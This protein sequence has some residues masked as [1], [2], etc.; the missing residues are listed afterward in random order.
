M[1]VNDTSA[2]NPTPNAPIPVS[3]W[4]DMQAEASNDTAVPLWARELAQAYV[5]NDVY[6][7]AHPDSAYAKMGLV[8]DIAKESAWPD[9]AW[10]VRL[11]AVLEQA[12][13]KNAKQLVLLLPYRSAPV[14]W[15]QWS[16]I[17]LERHGGY[18]DNLTG[19]FHGVQAQSQALN[20]PDSNRWLMI[21]RVMTYGTSLAQNDFLVQ[22]RAFNPLAR[23]VHDDGFL[24][25]NL[26]LQPI[27]AYHTN[28]PIARIPIK[29]EDL[30]AWGT[31]KV[32]YFATLKEVNRAK[33]ID[34]FEKWRQQYGQKIVRLWAVVRVKEPNSRLLVT[35]IHHLWAANF[36]SHDV[37]EN[38]F[39]IIGDHLDAAQLQT[40]FEQCVA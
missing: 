19:L 13:Q 21:D 24:D 7:L 1:S 16:L 23:W 22:M 40:E 12:K 14:L 30:R 28:V 25:K 37:P 34:L 6:V 3:I 10:S 32:V 33:V 29:N 35:S 39:W 36:S 31:N 26:L 15:G 20:R 9:D 2:A 11:A 8:C 5:D 4:F 27:N 18:L 17:H 38:R